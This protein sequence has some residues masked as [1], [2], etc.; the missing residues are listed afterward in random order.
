MA[1]C[2]RT[3]RRPHPPGLGTVPGFHP[4]RG[5]AT[6]KSCQSNTSKNWVVRVVRVNGEV[7]ACG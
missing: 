6:P 4:L 7:N 2:D 3:D 1:K 5:G